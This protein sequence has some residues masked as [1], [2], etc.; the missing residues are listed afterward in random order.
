MTSSVLHGVGSHHTC[1]I[2]STLAYGA[3][4][5][6]IRQAHLAAYY[7]AAL[8]PVTFG[9]AKRSGLRR[10]DME[11]C[12]VLGEVVRGGEGDARYV[13]PCKPSLPDPAHGT[14]PNPFCLLFSVK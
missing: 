14:P 12:L 6:G 8:V 11:R 9:T 7:G 3:T 2:R 13:G 1:I 4:I 5:D 10:T